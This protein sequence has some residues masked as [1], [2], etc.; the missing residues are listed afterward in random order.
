MV[1]LPISA[2]KESLDLFNLTMN[3]FITQ[4]KGQEPATSI[5]S[6]GGQIIYK[7]SRK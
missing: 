5:S 3:H 2:P 1:F 6:L 7:E 4:V